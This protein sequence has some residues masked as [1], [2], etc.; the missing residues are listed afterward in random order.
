MDFVTNWR[1]LVHAAKLAIIFSAAGMVF[2]FLAVYFG[3]PFALEGTDNTLG[4]ER[5][6]AAIFVAG[7][8]FGFVIFP[9]FRFLVATGLAFLFLWPSWLVF[10]GLCDSNIGPC[11]APKSTLWEMTN[12]FCA[13][14][15]IG[16]VF[17]GF[18]LAVFR[19]K[20]GQ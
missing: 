1:L 5:F 4:I 3:I 9:H 8:L 19:D 15:A 6:F 13:E 12:T 20:R 17:V 18:M 11:L 14:F 2:G 10:Y 16:A 7:L